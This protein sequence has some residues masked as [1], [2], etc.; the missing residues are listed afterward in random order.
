MTPSPFLSRITNPIDPRNHTPLRNLSAQDRQKLTEEH[1]NSASNAKEPT[2]LTGLV[3]TVSFQLFLLSGSQTHT[4]LISIQIKAQVL[5]GVK[6]QKDAYTLVDTA[7]FPDKILRINDKDGGLTVMVIATMPE[8][9]RTAVFAA[10]R[11]IFEDILKHVDSRELREF[12]TIHLSYYNR[13]A[14]KV[15]FISLRIAQKRYLIDEQGTG[16]P[17]EA[18]PSSIRREGKK[19]VSSRMGIPRESEEAKEWQSYKGKLQEAFAPMF[20]WIEKTVS[21]VASLRGRRF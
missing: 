18:H 6:S 14:K 16:T 5:G 3:N 11:L 9:L 4:Y 7:L 12:L 17:A 21:L 19:H 15:S 8:E 2:D 1:R 20:A 13:Y 10:V